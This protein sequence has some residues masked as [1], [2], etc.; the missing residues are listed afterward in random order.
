M[1]LLKFSASGAEYWD[2]PGGRI[3]SV[4]S[5][6]KSKVTGSVGDVGESAKVNLD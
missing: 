2:S 1:T 5:F 4:I 3:A 6:V